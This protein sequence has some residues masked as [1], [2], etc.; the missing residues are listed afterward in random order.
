MAGRKDNRFHDRDEKFPDIIEFRRLHDAM[1]LAVLHAYGWDDLI[2][3]AVPIFLDD[4]N[5]DDH[6]YQGRYAAAG[7][8]ARRGGQ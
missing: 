6:K 1:D 3:L 5:E 2:P 8:T 4:T 7:L